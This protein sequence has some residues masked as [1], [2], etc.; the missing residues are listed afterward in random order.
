MGRRNTEK[1]HAKRVFYPNGCGTH[2][3]P[4]ISA[5]LLLSDTR[6]PFGSCLCFSCVFVDD[7]FVLAAD[8]A[9][10]SAAKAD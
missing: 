1:K 7:D 6:S 9:D 4:L 8:A 2:K 5:A 10:T 3:I